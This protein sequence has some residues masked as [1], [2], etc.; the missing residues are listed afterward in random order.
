MA[1][2]QRRRTFLL[3]ADQ[4]Q[5]LKLRISLQSSR[6]AAT[7]LSKRAS[8]YV[9]VSSLA[10]TCIVRAKSMDHFDDAYLL[11]FADARRRL[12][13]P[14]GEGFFGNCVK[15][16]YARANV[17][18]LCGEEGGL[19]C[20]A[21]A[22][23]DAI[24]EYVEE[25][26]DPFSDAEAFLGLYGALPRERVSVMGSSHR[27]MAYET[28]FGWGAPSRVELVSLFRTREMVVLLGASDG[29]VQLSVS[30]D[31][32]HMEAFQNNFRQVTE[33]AEV[34]TDP[35]VFT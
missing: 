3:S 32:P 19:A 22:I 10:W 18:D 17:G 16:C 6:D 20:A 25:L 8:A 2:Q 27:F 34:T 28:D 30:L 13:P 7:R 35:I 23:Q 12:R 31:Q 29:G 5:S 4:I 21:A 11:V 1:H 14:L 9:A 33:E 24:R 26:E 15:P